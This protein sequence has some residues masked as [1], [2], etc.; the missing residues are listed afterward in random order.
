MALQFKYEMA[1]L[2]ESI[3]LSK[4]IGKSICRLKEIPNDTEELDRIVQSADTI[5]GS[6]K[7]L[8][9]KELEINAKSLVDSLKGLWDITPRFYEL[10]YTAY[11]IGELLAARYERRSRWIPSLN[12]GQIALTS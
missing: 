10:C 12:P 2:N 4:I 7:F 1:F 8:G 5:M 3:K 11:E 9:D 6:A